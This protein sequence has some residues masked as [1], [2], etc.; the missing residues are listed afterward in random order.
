MGLTLVTFFMAMTLVGQNDAGAKALLDK[1]SN[2]MSSYKNLSLDFEYVLENKAADVE[3]SMSG[4]LVLSGDKY[5]VNLFG[6]T[7]L[8]DGS[9]TYTIIPE[10]EEVNISDMDVDDDNAFTPSK[11]YSFYKKGYTYTMA[12]KKTLKG[13]AVQFVRLTPMDSNSEVDSILVGIDTKT[14]HIYQIVEIG[15]NDTQT[16]LTAGNLKTNQTLDAGTFSFDEKKYEAMNYLI[17]K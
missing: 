10:N 17:N 15:K 7:Q 5:L 3:Q 9:K 16:T 4:T 14:N 6:T 12:E 1:A 2:T 11:I 13:M 8:F